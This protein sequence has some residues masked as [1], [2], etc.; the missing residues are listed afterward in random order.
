MQ[1]HFG[2]TKNESV[3]Y[4]TSLWLLVSIHPCMLECWP[5]F[6]STL[7]RT[8]TK[9]VR[10]GF[11]RGHRS[12]HSR[13]ISNGQGSN[14]RGCAGIRLRQMDWIS[15]KSWNIAVRNERKRLDR[16]LM[17]RLCTLG[18]NSRQW[19]LS[20]R[21]SYIFSTTTRKK[22]AVIKCDWNKIISIC[23]TIV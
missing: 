3:D 8:Q 9:V 12:Q 10:M 18:P 17:Q 11:C 1:T 20:S 22:E 2:W 5:I 15:S 19:R 14:V 23:L 13:C 21:C 4:L 6:P 16:F 7:A